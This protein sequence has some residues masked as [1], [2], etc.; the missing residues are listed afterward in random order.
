VAK[1]KAFSILAKIFALI[2]TDYFGFECAGAGQIGFFGFH[3]WR[4]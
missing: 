4:F 3:Y 1:K 2:E